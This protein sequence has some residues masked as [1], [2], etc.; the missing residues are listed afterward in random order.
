[1]HD[2]ST[3]GD[4]G[5]HTDPLEPETRDMPAEGLS[6]ADYCRLAEECL[7]LA[8]LTKDTEKAAELVKT[9]DDYL[10]CA[11][12]LIADQLKDH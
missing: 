10:R 8:A 7:S 5:P 2:N 11:A 4:D 12:Q 9:G 6:A 3:G 1:M